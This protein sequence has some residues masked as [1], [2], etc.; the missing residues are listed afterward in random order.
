MRAE[1]S[2]QLDMI[3]GT[4]GTVEE[5]IFIIL[6]GFEQSECS[7]IEISRWDEKMRLAMTSP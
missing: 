1:Q 6:P 5:P 7:R 4:S 2:N 3:E